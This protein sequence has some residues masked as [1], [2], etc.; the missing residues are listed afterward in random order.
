MV[1]I[2]PRLGNKKLIFLYKNNRGREDII[3]DYSKFLF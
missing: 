3:F 1:L 2:H